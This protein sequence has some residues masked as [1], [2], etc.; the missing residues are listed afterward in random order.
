MGSIDWRAIYAAADAAIRGDPAGEAPAAVGGAPAAAADELCLHCGG[1]MDRSIN[2]LGRVCA[3][4]GI[5]AND[6][7]AEPEDDVPRVV[8]DAARLRIVG[9]GSGHLQPDLYRSGAGSTPAAQISSTFEELI[10]YC[11]Y[12]TEGGGR[13]FPINTCLTAAQYYQMVQM[14]YVKRAVNKKRILAALLYYAGLKHGF[15]STKSEIAELTQLPSRGIAGG[16]NF[17][18]S[19]VADGQIDIDVDADTCRPEIS[20]LFANL[21]LAGPEYD[22]LRDTVHKI[23]QTAIREN[24][25]T[26]SILR[27]KVA[28]A[29][30]AVLARRPAV[31]PISLR[32]FCTAGSIRENTI[33]RFV[34]ELDAHSSIFAPIYEAAGLLPRVEKIASARARPAAKSSHRAAIV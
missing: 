27:S 10:T 8:T 3:E 23:V 31:P 18:R 14:N 17:I 16:I 20:T 7:A 24:V 34:R 4:C 11:R 13:A 26:N 32:E 33:G 9:P 2:D 6:E 19:L 15:A 25:G 28:G 22:D 12:F 29:T 21:N 30:Y 5:L 1:A